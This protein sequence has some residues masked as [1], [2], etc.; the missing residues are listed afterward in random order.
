MK[1][2]TLGKTGLLASVLGIGGHQYRW[3][4]G[5]NI[6]NGRHIKFD[7]GRYKIIAQAV[8]A[9]VNFFD[10]TYHEEVQSLGYDLEL[11]GCRQNVIVNGMII[12]V[13]RR[14]RELPAGKLERFIKAEL[15]ERLQLLKSDYFDI[16]MLC[17]IGK[18]YEPELVQNILGIYNELRDKGKFRFI[19]ASCHDYQTLY[20]FLLLNPNI[21]ILMLKYNY[22]IARNIET[23]EFTRVQGWSLPKVMQVIRKR[24]IGTVAI[25]VLS[26]FQPHI[27]FVILGTPK[28]DLNAVKNLIAWHIHR[29]QTDT[30]VIGVDDME[31]LENNLCGITSGPDE[32]FLDFY[33]ENSDCFDSLFE[34]YHERSADMQ[35][36]LIDVAKRFTCQDFGNDIGKYLSYWREIM[37]TKELT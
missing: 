37:H 23:T 7:P 15:D 21:D 35:L 16:F 27:P 30:F 6:K 9:G 34:Y 14:C 29:G 13:V 20:D 28:G 17:N 11:L 1:Y 25:K 2:K 26:W 32:E 3:Y 4:L 22:A 19:G 5:G 12:D 36:R 31:Q 10:T 33:L 18:G 8:E 24:N